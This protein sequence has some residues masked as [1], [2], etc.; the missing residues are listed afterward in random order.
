MF[1]RRTKCSNPAC[2]CVPLGW[3]FHSTFPRG[4]TDFVPCWHW[5]PGWLCPG[6]P[7]L[8]AGVWRGSPTPSPALPPRSQAGITP[9]LAACNKIP[10]LVKPLSSETPDGI[11]PA[12]P[13]RSDDG[14]RPVVTELGLHSRGFS[15][16]PLNPLNTPP[17]AG[18]LCS[19]HGDQLGSTNHPGPQHLPKSSVMSKVP[20]NP[21]HF[22][23]P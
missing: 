14:A 22:V 16:L 8:C 21:N 18:A 11:F 13:A 19:C 23:I 12:P 4:D 20:D 17:P 3:I 2:V 10:M 1:Y 9:A 6:C 5:G 15:P 7:Q